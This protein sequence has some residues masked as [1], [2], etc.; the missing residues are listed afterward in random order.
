MTAMQAELQKFKQDLVEEGISKG[1]GKGMSQS[2]LA[3]LAAR[4]HELPFVVESLP[5]LVAGFERC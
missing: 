1:V 2:I 3:F 4:P 5:F